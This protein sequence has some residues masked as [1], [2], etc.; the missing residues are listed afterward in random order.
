MSSINKRKTTRHKYNTRFK[1]Q[2][3]YNKKLYSGNDDDDDKDDNDY[4][5]EDQNS[6]IS[7][8]KIYSES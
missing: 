1:A 3:N 6:S 7:Q 4:I 8:E 2:N 5:L